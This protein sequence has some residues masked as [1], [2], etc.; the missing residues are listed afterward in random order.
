[1]QIG[2]QSQVRPFSKEEDEEPQWH[3]EER[4]VL[5]EGTW[6]A[7]SYEVAEMDPKIKPGH[8]MKTALQCYIVFFP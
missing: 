5:L 6:N 8:R 7:C 2:N 4:A 3:P 1:M